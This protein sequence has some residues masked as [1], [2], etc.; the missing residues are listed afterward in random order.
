[1]SNYSIIE[2]NQLAEQFKA[3]SNPHRLRIFLEYLDCCGRN[4]VC[5]PVEGQ[6]CCVG[7]VVDRLDLAPATV[8]HH[9]KELRRAGLIRMERRGRHVECWV[10]EEAA[11]VLASVFSMRVDE[12]R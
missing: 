9:L 12:D 1:M 2:L 3:L 5:R 11:R 4:G 10:D 8:S 6:A 7:N